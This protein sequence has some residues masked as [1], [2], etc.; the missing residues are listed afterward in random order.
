M[1]D[2][3]P[4]RLR[5]V[6]AVRE[7]GKEGEK[8]LIRLAVTNTS[9][10]SA[11]QCFLQDVISGLP[12]YELKRNGVKGQFV[13]DDEWIAQIEVSLPS[14]SYACRLIYSYDSFSG[15]LSFDV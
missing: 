4:G 12:Y 10:I 3:N 15:R 6:V 1:L 8:A 7:N 14:R 5:R 11:G 13:M 9:T 2:F